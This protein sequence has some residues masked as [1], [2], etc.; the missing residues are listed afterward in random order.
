VAKAQDVLLGVVA[1]LAEEEAVEAMLQAL[2][3]VALQCSSSG[4]DGLLLTC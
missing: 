1:A 2:E 4:R 3:E